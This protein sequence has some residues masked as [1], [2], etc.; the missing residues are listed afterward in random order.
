MI[1]RSSYY[2]SDEAM[3]VFRDYLSL[4][5]TDSDFANART[6]RNALEAARLRHAFRL[7]SEPDRPW[8][9]DDLMRLERSDVLADLDGR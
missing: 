7:A 3:A 8:S 5:R 6:V 9:M 4:H 1:D 2:L